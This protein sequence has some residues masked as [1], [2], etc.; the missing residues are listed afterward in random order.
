MNL[1]SRGQRTQLRTC[2]RK[3]RFATQ[4]A[5]ENERDILHERSQLIDGCCVA[6]VFRAYECPYCDGWH[7]GKTRAEG[8]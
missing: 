4:A 3:M 6:K 1:V 2:D 7:V 8:A 5:A